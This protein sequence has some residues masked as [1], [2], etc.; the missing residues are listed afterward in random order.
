MEAGVEPEPEDWGHVRSSPED[1]ESDD[2]N[3]AHGA[4]TSCAESNGDD[5]NEHR[6]EA[7][8]G[9]PSPHPEPASEGPS[10]AALG[11][12]A[13]QAIVAARGLSASLAARAR[14]RQQT[15]NTIVTEFFALS[16]HQYSQALASQ[17]LHM[18]RPTLVN[19]LWLS[20]HSLYTSMRTKICDMLKASMGICRVQGGEVLQSYTQPLVFVRKRKYDEAQLR[21]CVDMPA[22]T[23]EDPELAEE[24]D[25]NYGKHRVLVLEGGFGMALRRSSLSGESTFCKVVGEIP[26][27]L[28]VI[29]K[30]NGECLKAGQREL[31]LPT[32]AELNRTFY[33]LVDLHIHD[34]C[35]SNLRSERSMHLDNCASFGNRRASLGL[36]CDAHKKAQ[37]VGC[38]WEPL[39]PFDT[40]LVRLALSTRG[41][42]RQTLRREARKVVKYNLVILHAAHPS[43]EADIHR[44]AVFRT[45]CGGDTPTAKFRRTV[46]QS[47]FNG[48]VRRSDRIEHLCRVCCKPPRAT[49]TL[50]CTV[51]IQP[52]FPKLVLTSAPAEQL[53]R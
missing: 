27:R 29:E 14:Q 44:D 34:E 25:N 9:A 37:Y 23:K 31:E 38:A 18:S 1:R 21:L 42:I 19:K 26:C 45:F 40:R 12:P 16:S 30:N 47:L 8:S 53:D 20:A 52:R 36:L 17:H 33:R 6:R 32:D 28:Q 51:G 48:D 43:V 7:A 10:I 46:L 5:W 49:V 3:D 50:F 35:S 2:W 4:E 24:Y 15:I 41:T 39:R 22:S 11:V 13:C